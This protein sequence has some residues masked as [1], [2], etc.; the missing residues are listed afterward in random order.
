MTGEPLAAWQREEIAGSFLA[1]RQAVLPLIDVQEELIRELLA[2]HDR[3]IGRFLDV[4][5]GDGAMSALVRSAAPRAEAVLVDFS[6]PMLERAGARLGADGWRAVRGDLSASSWAA[7]LPPGPYDAAVSAYAIHHLTR[8]RKRALYAELYELLAPGAIFVNMDCVTI[9]GPLAGLFDERIA[10]AHDEIEGGQRD[11]PFE[12]T[13]EDRPDPAEDQ[14]AW[15]RE[16]GFED[17][18]LHFKWAEGAIF[19]GTKPAPGQRSA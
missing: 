7:A 5:A 18:E 19:G 15:L 16:A 2:R 9:R 13:D 3:P 10:A 8:E 1:H 12:D 17:V 11:E 14:L 6:E 4:G